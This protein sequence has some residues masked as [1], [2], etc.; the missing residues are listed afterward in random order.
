MQN[1]WGKTLAAMLAVV[2]VG[3]VG[4]ACSAT[5]KAATSARASEHGKTTAAITVWVDAD[6]LAGIEAYKKSH[7]NAP[8]NVV[9][10]PNTP[11]YIE[12]KISL[13]N[14]AGS[15]W[16][17]VVFL[18]SPSD[19]AFLAAAPFNYALNI[20]KMVSRRTLDNFGASNAGCTFKGQ[21]YCLRDDIGQTVLWYNAKEMAQFGYKVPKTWSQYQALG[22][23]VSKQHP[24]YI[25]GSLGGKWGAGTYFTASGCKTRDVVNLHTVKID[26]SSSDCTRVARMLQPLVD[27]GTVTALDFS[28]PRVVQMAK[29]GKV[30]MMPGPSWYGLNVFDA[31]YKV[32]AGQ[33]AVSAMPA[34]PGQTTG[35]SGS[36]GGG[37]WVASRH[38][39]PAQ[40]KAALQMMEWLTTNLRYQESLQTYPAYIPAAK[41][42][43]STQEKTHYFVGNVC[44]VLTAAAQQINPVAGTVRYEPQWWDSYDATIQAAALSKSSLLNAL[45]QWGIQLK[46]AASEEGYVV[47][48]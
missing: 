12:T 45:K 4:C 35:T 15:G 9:T 25:I 30:L 24:G 14:R 43:C 1:H 10:I 6:R 18:N 28:D 48:K 42:W 8:V 26:T 17:N 44:A 36:V 3:I 33:M 32:P 2:V 21:L 37:M 41:A 34:W 20:T 11:G 47:K 40:R 7:P 23:E 31:L 22:E 19:V 39:T 38:S 13:A 46:E 27:D 16:P 5:P 29:S